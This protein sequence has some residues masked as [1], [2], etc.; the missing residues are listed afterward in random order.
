VECPAL[1]QQDRLAEQ[2]L[3]LATENQS[4]VVV[5]QTW[6]EIHK[7]NE[8]VRAALKARHLIGDEDKTVTALEPVD[9]TDAQKRDKRFYTEESVLMF[10]RNAG[11]FKKGETGRMI[12]ITD[13]GVVVEGIGK[14]R[15]IRFKQLDR[16]TVCRRSEFALAS[17]DRLQLKAN[18]TT[19]RGQRLANGELVT[20]DR[21]LAD[22]RIKLQD[23]RTLEPNYRQ[24]I[25]G[26]AITSYASQGK[27][28][29]YVL[30]SDSVIRAA[31]N[32]QQ[33]YVTISRGR[34]GI[35]IFT[36]DKTQLRENILRSGNRELAM[37][38][39][40]QE[41]IRRLGISPAML[42]GVPPSRAFAAA[43]SLH[44]QMR[45]FTARIRNRHIQQTTQ[46]QIP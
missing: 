25:R 1:D 36:S 34:K 44:H 14:I 16:L 26:F 35:H 24:F 17:G 32:Q 9:L 19:Q 8:R 6:S 28:V 4:V 30:F 2:Y 3:R 7:V 41:A 18:A 27:T 42:R 13:G 37:D 31:T 40:D 39:A 23:G 45:L 15:T 29:D 22:G 38:L 12:A 5:S 11:G 10:N 20:V 33:W 43:L 21:V 46:G